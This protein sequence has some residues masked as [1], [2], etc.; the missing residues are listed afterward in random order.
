MLTRV[1]KKDTKRA[2]AGNRNGTASESE[3]SRRRRRRHA[4]AASVLKSFSALDRQDSPHCVR[5]RDEATMTFSLLSGAL[6]LGGKRGA[7]RREGAR[8]GLVFVSF[9]FAWKSLRQREQKFQRIASKASVVEEARGREKK[10]EALSFSL[11]LHFSHPPWLPRPRIRP[12]PCARRKRTRTSMRV[13]CWEDGLKTRALLSLFFRCRSR[14]QSR[15]AGEEN[16]GSLF[17]SCFPG[18]FQ[19]SAWNLSERSFRHL[20]GAL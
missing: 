20:G 10:E 15:P 9:A 6:G 12:R 3:C 5:H 2:P 19:S 14:T 4:G 16:E 18:R 13:R 17:P 8:R 7:K 1:R 11:S